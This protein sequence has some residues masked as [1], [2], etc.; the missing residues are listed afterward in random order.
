MLM[1][2]RCHLPRNCSFRFMEGR[3]WLMCNCRRQ[4]R[5]P[6]GRG[7]KS[8]VGVRGEDKGNGARTREA[9]TERVGATDRES[10]TSGLL[11]TM[12]LSQI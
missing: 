2:G 12:L 7:G 11:R 4:P 1:Y 8:Q 5:L 6:L 9:A 3:N 10:W